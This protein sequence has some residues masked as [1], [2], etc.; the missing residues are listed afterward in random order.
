VFNREN[1]VPPTGNRNSSQ[2]M[3]SSAAQFARQSQFGIRIR[4]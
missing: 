1:L 3:V 2:F 4:F